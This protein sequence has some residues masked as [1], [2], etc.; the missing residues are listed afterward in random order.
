MRLTN[1]VATV[2][3]DYRTGPVRSLPEVA[4]I[5]RAHGDKTMSAGTAWPWGV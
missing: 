5:M 4:R 2:E 1:Q 3:A